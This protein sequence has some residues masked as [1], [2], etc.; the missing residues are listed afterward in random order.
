[1]TIDTHAPLA[2]KIKTKRDHNSWFDNDS[3][4]LKTQ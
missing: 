3:Q 1:M 2:T 4:K